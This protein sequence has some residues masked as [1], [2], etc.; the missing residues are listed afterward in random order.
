MLSLSHP[1][2]DFWGCTMK[3]RLF[4]LLA[5][6]VLLPATSMAQHSSKAAE[7]KLSDSN[8]R[9]PSTRAVSL[10]GQVSADGKTLVSDGDDIWTVTNPSVLQG[11]EAQQVLVKC[12]VNQ[13]KNE[14]QVFSVKVR[15]R[16]VKYVV[17]RSDSAFRR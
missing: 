3:K 4:V 8:A 7:S 15:P 14:I 10:S 17:N 6:A 13:A 2:I 12:Q 9:K 1:F 16:E 5:L 11:Y